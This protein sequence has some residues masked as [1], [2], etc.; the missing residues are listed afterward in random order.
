MWKK[1]FSMKKRINPTKAANVSAT[2]IK[3]PVKK[4]FIMCAMPYL[5]YSGVWIRGL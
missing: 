3:E 1:I 5:F 2:R 4:S